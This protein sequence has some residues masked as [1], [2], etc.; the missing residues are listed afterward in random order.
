VQSDEILPGP[1]WR[2]LVHNGNAARITYQLRVSCDEFYGNVTCLAYCKPRND[3]FG[4]WYCNDQAKMVCLDGW[5]GP[6]CE[7]GKCPA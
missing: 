6:N 4:H 5:T 1:M 7:K 3:N 2:K